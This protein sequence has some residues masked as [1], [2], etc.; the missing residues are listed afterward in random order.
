MVA[1]AHRGTDRAAEVQDAADLA[2]AALVDDVRGAAAPEDDALPV[3]VRRGGVGRAEART[4]DAESHIRGRCH[5]LGPGQLTECEHEAGRL[6]D[7]QRA[8]RVDQDHGTSSSLEEPW[9][10]SIFVHVWRHLEMNRWIFSYTFLSFYFIGI[11]AV[12]IQD[13]KRCTVQ[14]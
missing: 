1:I 6:V 2:A 4:G 7:L 11:Q 13:M 3:T 12:C 10:M 9:H 14:L 5:A 8:P